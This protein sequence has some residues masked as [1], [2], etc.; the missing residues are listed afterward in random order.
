M[1]NKYILENIISKDLSSKAWPTWL[2]IRRSINWKN[3]S[4]TCKWAHRAAF[5]NLGSTDISGLIIVVGA[6]FRPFKI[7]SSCASH[8]SLLNTSYYLFPHLQQLKIFADADKY[9]LGQKHPWL[10]IIA[11][12][13]TSGILH[14]ITLAHFTSSF[15]SQVRAR[16]SFSALFL[17]DR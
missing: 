13:G 17:L 1:Q 12:E 11:I 2:T 9:S 10:R 14:A 3:L 8:L 4:N 15:P 5:C 16:Y 6:C 7:F